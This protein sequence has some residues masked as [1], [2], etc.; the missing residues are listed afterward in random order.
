MADT[1]PD[2]DV[3]VAGAGAAGLAA[4]LAAAEGGCSVV[5]L[6]AR[7]TYRTGSNTAMSTSMVPAGGSRWQEALGIDDSPD[8][9]FADLLRKTHGEAAPDVARA[10]T[11]VAPEL[12]AWMAD[13]LGV[14]FE[15]VTDFR[16]PG[17]SRDR[18]HALP[19]RSGRSM[20]RF[21]LEAVGEQPLITLA[22]P[23]RLADVS[24]DEGGAVRG[25]EVET[26]DGSREPISAPSVVLATNGFGADPQLVRRHIPEIVDG[27]Y[28]GGDGSLGD[29]IR[30]GE[31]HG[32]DLGFLDAYQGHGSLAFPH[33]V[34]LTWA[35]VMYGAI[36]VNQRGERFG[37]ETSG[38]SEYAAKTL[39]QPSGVAWMVFDERVDRA[40]RVFA[41]YQDV[42]SSNAVRW[43]DDLPGLA[44][45][46]GADVG[47][48]A[49]TIEEADRAAR[50]GGVDSFGRDQWGGPLN[51]P[52]AAVRVTGALFHTQGGLRVDGHARVLRGGEPVPGLYAAGGAAAGISG[53]GAAGYLAGN[54]LLSALGLGYLAG[55]HASATRGARS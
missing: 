20:H 45:L 13:A 32:F 18:C 35:T 30:I 54:G 10:L 7:P 12:V 29:A 34:L 4:A 46:V 36:L 11:G 43:A 5:L 41:D 49:A 23:M 51:P 39:A 6:D 8:L 21:L 42:V 1:E 44:A 53:H 2:A 38:Y 26:P 28:H 27:V 52:Y 31:R 37:D 15:L 9:L 24:L 3:V 22:V 17:H 47:V 25:A 14:P 33:G 48:L 16:Y 40:C 50:T 55:R 19:D